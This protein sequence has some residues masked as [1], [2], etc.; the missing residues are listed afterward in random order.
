MATTVNY[1]SLL[2]DVSNA[3]ER[4]GSLLTDPTVYNQLP[5]LINAAERAL[6]QDLKLLGTIEVLVNAPTGLATGVSVYPKPDRWRATVSMNF[7]AGTD[8]NDRTPLFPRSYEYA[9][10]YWPNSTTTGVPRYYT[11]Y[12]LSS[13]LVVPTPDDDYPWEVLAYM[14]PVLLDEENQ[15]NF[16][17]N[18]CPNALYYGTLLQAAPFI[19]DDARIATWGNAYTKE[20]STLQ[21]QDLQRIMDRGAVRTM[22]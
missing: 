17:T 3:L 19:K 20:V 10:S 5:R 18:Y 12:N 11:D 13:W 4:G 2:A 14:Q 7:G 9:R 6:I 21:A 22:V 16:F 1:T 8:K 15:N